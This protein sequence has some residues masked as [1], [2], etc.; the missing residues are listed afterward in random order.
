MQRVRQLFL[1]LL[2]AVCGGTMP[3]GMAAAG[4]IPLPR[5]R[6][7]PDFVPFAE[8]AR[9]FFDPAELTVEPSACRKRLDEIAIVAP[10]PRLIGPGECGGADM[11]RLSAVRLP[12]KT[13][14]ALTPPPELRCPMAESV[15]AWV[16]DEIAP[17]FA[18]LGSPLRSVENY[19]SYECRGRNRVNG[20]KISEHG[21]GNA[22]DVRKFRLASGKAVDP[23]DVHFAKDFRASMRTA[24]CARF[25]TVLGP[26]SDGYHESHIHLDIAERQRGYRLCQWDVRDPPPPPGPEIALAGVPL[27]QPRPHIPGGASTANGGVRN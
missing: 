27:P 19:D 26:G 17:K 14:V 3:G 13:T 7:G 16:R 6:P 5:P 2:V 15:A 8:S 21:K 25:T 9:P 20:A 1:I 22:L 18:A 23:T 4:D 10:V 24:A 12:D 11:V